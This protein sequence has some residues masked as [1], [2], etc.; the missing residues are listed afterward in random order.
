MGAACDDLPIE[1]LAE[2][3]DREIPLLRQRP[4]SPGL[5]LGQ[6]VLSPARYADETL[7]PLLSLVRR[8]KKAL[9]AELPRRFFFFHEGGPGKFTGYHHPV[10][11]GSRQRRGPYQHP[12]YRRPPGDLA[13]LTTAQILA[14][15][16]D[17]KGLEVAWLADPTEALDA[18]IEGS[19]MIELED[20]ASLN[21]TT[22]GHNGG[23]YVN[24]SRLLL[25]DGKVDRSGPSPPPGMTRVRRYFQDHP[26]EL[27]TYWS[28]NPHFVFFKETELRGTGAF[29]ELVPGRSLAVDARRVPMGAALWVRSEKPVLDPAAPA[30]GPPVPGPTRFV[31]FSRLALAQ[32][33]GAA[34]VGRNRVDL[35]FGVGPVAQQAATVENRPGQVYVLLARP[36]KRHLARPARAGKRSGG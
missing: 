34:I 31:P 29:G 10:Y 7:V 13:S 17:N 20:G 21:L 14:G 26:D 36:S 35:F 18:H 2:A 8:G 33:T 32:D 28:K 22:D 3:I 6:T 5:R 12:L 4:P 25:A 9:C 16:L 11:K 30:K 1:A 19:A 24:V 23:A 27:F 15:G